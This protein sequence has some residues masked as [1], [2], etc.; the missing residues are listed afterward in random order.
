MNNVELEREEGVGARVT[1]IIK[2][3]EQGKKANKRE[4]GRGKE[5]RRGNTETIARSIQRGLN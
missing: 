3:T 5:E 1:E 4:K 2:A